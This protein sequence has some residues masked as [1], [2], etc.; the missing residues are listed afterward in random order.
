MQTAGGSMFASVPICAEV[1][2]Y[3]PP[4]AVWTRGNSS[5]TQ[6]ACGDVFDKWR[7]PEVRGPSV[8]E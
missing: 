5:A 8:A 7:S 2:L 3:M 6:F 1:A 4:I